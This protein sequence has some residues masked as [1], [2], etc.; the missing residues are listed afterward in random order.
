MT[1]YNIAIMWSDK[2][3]AI[4]QQA[5]REGNYTAA[6]A[7]NKRSSHY[8]HIARKFSS[9]WQAYCKVW[10]FQESPFFLQIWF[11]FL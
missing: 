11:T 5:Y 4:A 8:Y 2:Y 9:T 1:T 7:C 3:A 10:G 6:Y